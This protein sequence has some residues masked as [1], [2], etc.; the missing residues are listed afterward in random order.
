[1]K[2]RRNVGRKTCKA[3]VDLII[4]RLT[5]GGNKGEEEEGAK[6]GEEEKET[7]KLARKLLKD[8]GVMHILVV[9][10]LHVDN[11]VQYA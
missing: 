7:Q 3:V 9:H 4:R 5:R 10:G 1:M 6:T 8:R 2:D 11:I